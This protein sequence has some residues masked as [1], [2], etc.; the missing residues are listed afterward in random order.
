M[1]GN[2]G[3]RLTSYVHKLHWEGGKLTSDIVGWGRPAALESFPR[4][5]DTRDPAMLARITA[6]EKA[7]KKGHEKE[8]TR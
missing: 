4:P 2:K 7:L 1:E 8:S 5:A 3:N 6:W